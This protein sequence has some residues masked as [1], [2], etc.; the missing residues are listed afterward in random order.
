[1]HVTVWGDDNICKG[2]HARTL[3]LKYTL[4]NYLFVSKHLSRLCNVR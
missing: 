3:K 2:N 1:M 4:S